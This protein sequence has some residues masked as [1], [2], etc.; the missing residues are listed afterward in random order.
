MDNIIINPN[1]QENITDLTFYLNGTTVK[2]PDPASYNLKSG[3]SLQVNLTVPRTEFTSGS[4]I[5]ICV[6][7]DH[8]GWN[9]GVVLP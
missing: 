5:V 9:K 1:S 7:G 2:A 6:M 3:D 8:F 4:T